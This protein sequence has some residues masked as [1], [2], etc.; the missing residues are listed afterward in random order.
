MAPSRAFCNS[1]TVMP[2]VSADA[3]M[4]AGVDHVY[5][6][7]ICSGSE[8]NEFIGKNSRRQVHASLAC[9][10]VLEQFCFDTTRNQTFGLVAKQTCT[11]T[12]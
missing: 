1:A 12:N 9:L 7:G 10:S 6:I 8:S 3:A 11:E 4:V 2:N 5:Y